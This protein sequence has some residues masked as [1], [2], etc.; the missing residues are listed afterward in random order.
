MWEAY[1]LGGAELMLGATESV[2]VL[3]RC[4]D[5]VRVT[6]TTVVDVMNVALGR[7][8][9][10]SEEA[11]LEGELLLPEDGEE[12]DA[13]LL[14]EVED[15]VVLLVVGMALLIL[16]ISS[17]ASIPM[18]VTQVTAFP[19][20]LLSLSLPAAMGPGAMGCENCD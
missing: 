3:T 16:V 10:F 11:E 8:L 5:G 1:E 18:A 15:A 20:A 12:E 9:V 19:W 17:K 13:V 6:T 2:D 14:T 4:V 7:V